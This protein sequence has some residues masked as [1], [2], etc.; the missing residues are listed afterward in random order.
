MVALA[1]AMASLKE[2]KTSVESTESAVVVT[3]YRVN[4]LESIKHF[5]S[6][7]HRAVCQ[8]TMVDI[9][10]TSALMPVW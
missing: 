1:S 7:V 8:S 3:V 10:S 4:E 6:F 5:Y 9:L 2:R